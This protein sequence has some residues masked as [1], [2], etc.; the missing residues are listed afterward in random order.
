MDARREGS[1]KKQ[2]QKPTTV[3]DLNQ[4]QRTR[5]RKALGGANAEHATVANLPSS[6]A[7][8]L[9]Q[10]SLP[11]TP[12]SESKPGRTVSTQQQ[13]PMARPKDAGST[14]VRTPLLESM[15]RAHDI[16]ADQVRVISWSMHPTVYSTLISLPCS[17]ASPRSLSHLGTRLCMSK[18]DYMEGN[19]IFFCCF[20]LVQFLFNC[21]H[22]HVQYVQMCVCTKWLALF[23]GPTQLSIACVQ[24]EPGT[25]A[26]EWWWCFQ[27]LYVYSFW[28]D[29]DCCCRCFPVRR[30]SRRLFFTYSRGDGR[31]CSSCLI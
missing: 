13:T 27:L 2:S 9:H 15:P 10:H 6:L 25:E 12:L 19:R 7:V 24:G 1:S 31:L 3:R 30:W 5:A 20:F 4:K 22:L 8:S 28:P 16:L 26:T 21:D 18:Y 29:V 11:S 17:K 23:P 14:T